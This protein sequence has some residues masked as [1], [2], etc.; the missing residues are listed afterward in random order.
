MKGNLGHDPVD[1]HRFRIRFSALD[2][3]VRNSLGRL[4]QFLKQGGYGGETRDTVETV[5]G[6]VLN[7]VVEHAYAGRGDGEV[8]L[9][10]RK[11]PGV[12]C[13]RVCDRGNPMPGLTLPKGLPAAIEKPVQRLPEGGFGWFLVRTLA[14]DLRY[15]RESDLNVLTFTIP[16]ASEG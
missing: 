15:R 11:G 14:R 7:N 16:D 8:D 1:F 4:R 9:L 3:D 5:L 6:E 2:L 13:F 10:F 12:L